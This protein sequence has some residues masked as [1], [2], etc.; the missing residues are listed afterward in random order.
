MSAYN[1]SFMFPSADSTTFAAF[2]PRCMRACEF[3]RQ[4]SD[5]SPLAAELTSS[6]C[7]NTLAVLQVPSSSCHDMIHIL[8]GKW[9]PGRAGRTA[10][11][12]ICWVPKHPNR[13][14][15]W[16]CLHASTVPERNLVR[17]RLYSPGHAGGT[18]RPA[19]CCTEFNQRIHLS[20]FILARGYNPPGRA[21]R[22]ARPACR[23]A[24]TRWR[25]HPALLPPAAGPDSHR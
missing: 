3:A 19:L 7:G 9:S 22:T 1:T 16:F 23:A 11:P 12:A 6:S 4:A 10:R 13:S 15:S 8:R 25:P 14:Q 17:K 2:R 18:A 21:G 5:K 24:P 20:L